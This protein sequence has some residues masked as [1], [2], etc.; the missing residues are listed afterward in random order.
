MY[1][2]LNE[3]SKRVLKSPLAHHLLSDNYPTTIRKPL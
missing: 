1:I 3:V 2:M